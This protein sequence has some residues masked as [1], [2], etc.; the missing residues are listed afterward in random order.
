MIPVH[1]L[2]EAFW[3]DVDTDLAEVTLSV[4]VLCVQ[5]VVEALLVGVGAELPPTDGAGDD[6][7]SSASYHLNVGQR[8]RNGKG[9]MN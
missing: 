6:H 3:G 8:V 2:L 4:A 7:V 5:V 9:Y 1:V